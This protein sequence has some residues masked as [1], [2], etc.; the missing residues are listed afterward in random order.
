MP[1]G[2][3]RSRFATDPAGYN[4]GTGGTSYIIYSQTTVNDQISN[5]AQVY[6]R[7]TQLPYPRC[8]RARSFS[9]VGQEMVSRKAAF[10]GVSM[11]C[12]IEGASVN[13]LPAFSSCACPSAFTQSE[14]FST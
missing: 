7:L 10:S 6:R 3:I 1:R 11:S 13:R 2:P 8:S 12:L 9:L 4:I 5:V 14:P